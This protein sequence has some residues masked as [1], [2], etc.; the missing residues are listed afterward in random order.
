MINH[1][2]N[3]PLEDRI[4]LVQDLWDSIAADQNLLSLTPRTTR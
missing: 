2:R 3:L 1:L 4:Q